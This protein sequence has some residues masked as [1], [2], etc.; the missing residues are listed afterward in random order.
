M[1]TRKECTA[2]SHL[3]Y[4]RRMK[5]DFMEKGICA[6]QGFKA[7]GI[8]AGFKKSPS[9]KDLSLIFAEKECN[10]AAVY[11]QNKV[12]GAPI[13][14]SKEHLKDGK[15]RAILTNSGNANTCAPNGVDVAKAACSILAAELEINTEDIIVCSTGVIGEE[16][17]LMPFQKGMPRLVKK[18]SDDGS[19]SAAKG[20]M[21]TDKVPKEIAVSFIMDG[22]QCKIGGI[23]KGSGM[24]NPNMATMLSFITTDVNISS[25][26]LQ[27]ALKEDIKDSFNQLT[28]DGDTSTNDTLAIMASCMA[29]NKEITEKGKAYKEFLEALNVVTTYLCRELAKD[30]EG[31]NKLLETVVSGAPSIETAR[32]VSKSITDSALV[33]TAVFGEDANWGRVLCALGY[34]DADFSTENVDVSISSKSGTIDVCKGTTAVE[35]SEDKAAE[36]FKEDE[37]MLLVNL[38]D[39][40]SQAAAYG[41]DLT[42]SYVKINGKYR[43]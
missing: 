36:V 38:N 7:S 22:K 21:T 37:I 27:E 41:C 13:I 32:T 11:T 16:L 39:G 43:T 17:S 29:G 10:A 1:N 4:E 40:D 35:F 20:I 24:V 15:A 31:A 25:E 34:A 2:R 14:V 5:T 9:K 42:Y 30:G 8:H 3:P 26:M 12:K 28:I 18:L 6:P 33:K 19:N 23:A